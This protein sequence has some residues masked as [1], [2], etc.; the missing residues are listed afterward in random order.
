MRRRDADFDT[1]FRQFGRSFGWHDFTQY[2]LDAPFPDLTGLGDNSFKTRADA[3]RSR[4][5]EHGLT[6][7]QVIEEV[8]TP[9]PSPFVGSPETV[10]N[11]IH[12]WFD[13]GGVVG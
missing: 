6:L 1:F 10:A 4:A 2:D 5:R 12:E 11:L 13:D 3:V 8:G 9:Q 7:R